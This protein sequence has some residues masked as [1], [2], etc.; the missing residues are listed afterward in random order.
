MTRKKPPIKE[1]QTFQT[2]AKPKISKKEQIGQI[3]KSKTKNKQILNILS[4]LFFSKVERY[5]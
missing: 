2:E 1:P 3:I 4:P 5:S